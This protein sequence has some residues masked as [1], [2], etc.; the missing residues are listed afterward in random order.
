M[1]D[2]LQRR[3]RSALP[4]TSVADFDTLVQQMAPQWTSVLSGLPAGTATV[5]MNAPG[6]SADEPTGDDSLGDGSRYTDLGLLGTGGMG[7]VRRVRDV[8]LGRT[9]AMKIIRADLSTRPDVLARFIEE[10]QCSAQL[11]HPGIVPVHELGRLPDG[12]LYF[13]MAEVHGRTLGDVIAEVHRARQTDRWQR[14]PADWTFRRLVDAFRRVCEAVAY[15]HSRGVI[16]RD[17]KPENVMVGEHGE[18]LVVDWGLAKIRGHRDHAAEAGDL[19]ALR[20]EGPRMDAV[21]TDRSLDETQATVIGA[22]AGT[23]AYMPPEQ[24]RGDVDLI[25]AR[26]DVYALGAILYEILSG[27]APYEGRSGMEVLQKVLAGPPPPPGRRVGAAATLGSD[28]DLEPTAMA[29]HAGL[30]LPEDLVEACERAMAREQDTRFDNAATLAAEVTAWLEGAKRREKALAVV[31]DAHSLGPRAAALRGRAAELRAESELMLE[32]FA[33][34]EP[35]EKKAP[36]WAVADQADALDREVNALEFRVTQTLFGA[37]THAPDLPEAHAAL[38]GKYASEHAAAEA[39]RRPDATAHAEALLQFHA[40][41]LP[42]AHPVRQRTAVYFKGDGALTLVTDP[43]GAEVLLHRYEQH[44]RRLVPVLQRSLGR[45]PL[46]RLPLPMG[47]YLCVLR[48]DGRPEVHYPVHIGR[49]AHWDG[50]PPGH[51]EAQAVRLPRATELHPDE[52]YVPAGWFTAG[53]D[54][55]APGAVSRR[56][57]WADGFCMSRFP[58]TNHQY[59]A[60]LDDLVAQGRESEALRHAPC[61]R[62]GT[63]SEQGAPIYGYSNGRFSLRPD[64]DGD[65]WLADWPVC[66]VDWK[67]ATAFAAWHAKRT[68]LDWRLPH[69]LE[70]EKAARGVDGRFYPWGDGFDA[71]RCHMKDSH[72]GR[73]WPALVGQYALDESVYGVRDVAGN[74]RDWTAT[75]FETDG[76]VGDRARLT[77]THGVGEESSFRAFRGGNCFN[78]APFVR[79]ANRNRFFPGYRSND[80]SFR[81]ARS[82]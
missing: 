22:V 52:C 54:P 24:A 2:E 56:Q 34:W 38:A 35:E 74:M 62:G 60:F 80:L 8:D 63:Q 20:R 82:I 70:W 5:S 28:S 6:R 42:E 7:E 18:V 15:A 21:V 25:D 47:S 73:P 10:A 44:N 14:S 31:E 9:M 46:S 45:T 77:P 71:S 67:C 17:L 72:R 66:M 39:A 32:G 48:S 55:D 23:P 64:A 1:L 79:V 30:P 27:R 43:P 51:H 78:S 4:A 75:A 11:Q 40:A 12:R 36:G 3:V 13:T 49:G 50:A 53:G 58:V 59:I 33:L 57:V 65:E 26:S 16:H 37:L 69:E 81:L 68:G 29:A 19:K 61:E 76:A 41:A